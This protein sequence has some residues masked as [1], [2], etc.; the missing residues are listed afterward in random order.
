MIGEKAMKTLI[1]IKPR[2][3]GSR[4]TE[5]YL[6]Q[7]LPLRIGPDNN[8]DPKTKVYWYI[9]NIIIVDGSILVEIQKWGKISNTKEIGA[10]DTGA[11]NNL[12]K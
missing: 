9:M 2:G 10:K 4:T 11:H 5:S 7:V 6:N 1:Y 8:T 12:K 3:Q